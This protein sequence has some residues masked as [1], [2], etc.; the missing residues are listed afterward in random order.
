[1]TLLVGSWKALTGILIVET[2]VVGEFMEDEDKGFDDAGS[3]GDNL[4]VAMAID[5]GICGGCCAEVGDT[6]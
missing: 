3:I 2:E 4:A 5:A 6:C 1:M